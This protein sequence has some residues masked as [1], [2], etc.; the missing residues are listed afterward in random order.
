MQS[1]ILRGERKHPLL[2]C[3]HPLRSLSTSGLIVEITG[4]KTEWSEKQ[5]SEVIKEFIILDL[6]LSWEKEN[7]K[8]FWYLEKINI[9]LPPDL[10][11]SLSW[12]TWKIVFFI[13]FLLWAC[14]AILMIWTSPE[15]SLRLYG[16][17]NWGFTALGIY[18][19]W[20]LIAQANSL[21]YVNKLLWHCGASVLASPQ[22]L[23]LYHLN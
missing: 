2:P 7:H 12:I 11:L 16:K 22:L 10:A 23:F 19:K 20:K 15:A 1:E 6:L 4:Q 9:Q 8:F 13:I 18:Y 14:K 21:P 3:E 5:K 17:I